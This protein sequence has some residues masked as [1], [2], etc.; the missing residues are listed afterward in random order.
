[1]ATSEKPVR[2]DKYLADMGTETRSALKEMIRKG[3]VSVNGT[4][5]RDSGRHVKPAVDEVAVDGQ[6]V[7]YRGSFWYMMN[8]P[9]GVITATEDSRQ[10]TVLDLMPD[11]IR[12]QGVFPVGRLDRDT[13][14]LLLLTTDGVAAHAL[15]TPK[16]HVEKTYVAGLVCM[17]DP[18]A[19]AYFAA[20]VMISGGEVCKP[21]RLL[22]CVPVNRCVQMDGGTPVIGVAAEAA[23]VLT[24]GKFHQVKRMFES[25][26]S[27]VVTLRRIAFGGLD[28]DPALAPGQWRPLTEAETTHIIGKAG[29]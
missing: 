11:D 10:Q 27:R 6:P 8:K 3:R 17:P 21:A 26:H 15:L 29:R 20:G 2:L 19:A 28:L 12:R 7:S 24:E 16:R 9:A 18:D 14:G 13:E 1:M 23:L 5:E 25:V 22:S 4:M